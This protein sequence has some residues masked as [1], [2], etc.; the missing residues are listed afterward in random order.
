MH[1]FI[2]LQTGPTSFQLDL[3]VVKVLKEGKARLKSNGETDE[4]EEKTG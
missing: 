1:S 2:D 3:W 4:E